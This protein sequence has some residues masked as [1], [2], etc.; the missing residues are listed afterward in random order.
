MGIDV[1]VEAG[2]ETWEGGKLVSLQSVNHRRDREEAL[3]RHQSWVFTNPR[4]TPAG[5]SKNAKCINPKEEVGGDDGA[6]T[7]DLRRDRPAL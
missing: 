4:E 7:R 2:I 3:A 1:G 6:R 5:T